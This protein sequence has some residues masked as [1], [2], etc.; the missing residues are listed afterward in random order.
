MPELKS[1]LVVNVGS[2]FAGKSTELVRQGERHLLAG[3]TVVY[4]KPELDDR[5]S[6]DEIVTHDGQKAT[7]MTI[8]TDGC[9]VDFEQ[10][11]KIYCS[12]VILIDEIQFFPEN[13]ITDISFFLGLGKVVYIAGLDMDYTGDPFLITANLM[14]MADEVIKFKAVC[15]ECGDDSYVS[16]KESLSDERLE[17]GGTDLYKPLCRKCFNLWRD[18]K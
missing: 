2:M 1:K 9:P 10:F 8:K 14:A 4:I 18:E 3:H 7:A 13:F 17:V 16:A 6:E 15:K 12:D 11:D 5:Y